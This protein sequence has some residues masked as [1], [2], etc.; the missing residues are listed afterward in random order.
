MTS[1]VAQ[2]DAAAA[3]NLGVVNLDEGAPGPFGTIK[4]SEQI[5]SNL[6]LGLPIGTAPYA[7]EADGIAALD[8]GD[9]SMLLIV[10]PEFSVKAMAGDPT[11]VRVI[12]TQPLSIAEAQFGAAL[13]GQFQANMS[14][15][16]AL[17]REALARGVPPN[18]SA[19]LP[20]FATAETLHAVADDRA[21][22]APFVLMFSVW[23]AALVGAIMMHLASRKI[24]NRSSMRPVALVRTVVPFVTAGVGTLLAILVVGFSTGLWA[25]FFAPWL[26]LWLV[27]IAAAWLLMGLFSAFSFLAIIVALPLAFYQGTIAGIIAPAAAAAG[28]LAW[29]VGI[30]PVDDLMFGIRTILIGGPEGAVP[31]GTVFVVLLAGLV[32]IWVGTAGH[33]MRA[34]QSEAPS[35]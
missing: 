4:I 18:P 29:V 30:F 17:V 24:V 34:N 15:A 28:W 35:T 19:P 9:A 6:G 1:Q 31:L 23:P 10:P 5:L 21:L 26:Y 7:G 11:A 25:G 27:G 22:F 3:M 8:A 12:N 13:P 2:S 33:A 32:L 14:L 20:V 16:V